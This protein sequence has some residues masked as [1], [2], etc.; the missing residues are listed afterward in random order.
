MT[1]RTSKRW[2]ISCLATSF[3]LHL[4]VETG[5]S[6]N[7][8]LLLQSCR[9]HR[10]GT[11]SGLEGGESCSRRLHV[12]TLGCAFNVY[13]K[14]RMQAISAVIFIE[15]PPRQHLSEIGASQPCCPICG[16]RRLKSAVSLLLS[17]GLVSMAPATQAT[18]MHAAQTVR[19]ARL[20]AGAIQSRGTDAPGFA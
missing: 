5:E 6:S 9:C 1:G 12:C 10:I 20:E 17:C 2:G 3:S 4:F 15:L 8:H 13:P 11:R 7:P 16:D 14:F 19:G 18:Q